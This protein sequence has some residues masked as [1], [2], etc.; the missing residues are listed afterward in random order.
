LDFNWK[1]NQ[2]ETPLH[3]AVKYG[4]IDAVSALLEKG[5]YCYAKDRLGMTPEDLATKS[6]NKEIFRLLEGALVFFSN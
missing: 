4:C 6:H 5:V 3:V 1:N 2:G